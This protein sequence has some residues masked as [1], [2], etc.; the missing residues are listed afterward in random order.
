MHGVYKFLGLESRAFV[1]ILEEPQ[2]TLKKPMPAVSATS[3][4]TWGNS[5]ANEALLFLEPNCI[6]GSRNAVHATAC[7]PLGLKC[8]RE[9]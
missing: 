7:E 3:P 6:A 5:S 9:Y 2:L 4:L 1:E 8:H